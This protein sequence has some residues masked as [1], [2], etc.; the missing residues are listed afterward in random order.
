MNSPQDMIGKIVDSGIPSRD[1]VMTAYYRQQE[2]DGYRKSAAMTVMAMLAKDADEVSAVTL[3]KR[4]R[5]LADALTAEM[6][7][8][9]EG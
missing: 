3:A 9:T 5:A 8:E 7:P 4:A 1:E 6:F 2:K